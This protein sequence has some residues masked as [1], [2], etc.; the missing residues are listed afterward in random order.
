MQTSKTGGTLL[1]IHL[2]S[3]FF[4][5][6]PKYKY[7]HWVILHDWQW[8]SLG[9][10]ITLCTCTQERVIERSSYVNA[11]LMG[12][13]IWS[14]YKLHPSES[15]YSKPIKRSILYIPVVSIRE[16]GT[17][18]PGWKYKSEKSSRYERKVCQ[19][20][21]QL[22]YKTNGL[23][24]MAVIMGVD[25]DELFQGEKTSNHWRFCSKVLV[26]TQWQL[27]GWGREQRLQRQLAFCTFRTQLSSNKNL[28]EFVCS[29]LKAGNRVFLLLTTLYLDLVEFTTARSSK[30]QVVCLD[31][32][33]TINN[34]WIC[35]SLDWW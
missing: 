3:R 29:F 30:S 22:A 2:H 21:L 31:N 25:C 35:A 34:I 17:G 12:S 7:K 11:T 4:G 10:S 13:K 24:L 5:N 26:F 9:L 33:M 19:K 16:N 23:V 8:L 27:C 6:K 20:Q 28:S 32:F 1:P 14:S 18:V 15:K